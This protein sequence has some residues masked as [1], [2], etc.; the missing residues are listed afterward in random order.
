MNTS[1]TGLLYNLKGWDFDKLGDFK[2]AKQDRESALKAFSMLAEVEQSETQE[3]LRKER[4]Q[5]EWK[6]N[7]MK[8][9]IES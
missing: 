7:I 2:I 1:G 5:R 3:R 9:F 8:K 6:E 4:K